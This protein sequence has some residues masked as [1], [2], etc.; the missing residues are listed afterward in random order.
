MN[1]SNI[2]PEAISLGVTDRCCVGNTGCEWDGTLRNVK[3]E[4]I[5]VQKVFDA[6][7]VNLQALSTV[8]NVRLHLT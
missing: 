8:N 7:L 3:T 2:K 5:F 6:A 4:P 1:C